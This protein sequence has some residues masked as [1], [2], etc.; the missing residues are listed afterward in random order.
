MKHL[1]YILLPALMFFIPASYVLSY[2]A[3]VPVKNRNGMYQASYKL[4]RGG[5]VDVNLPAD[6]ALDESVSGSVVY[7]GNLRQFELLI[8]DKPVLMHGGGNFTY[9]LPGN[10]ST[11]VVKVV[12]RYTNGIEIGKAF[13]PVNI[14]KLRKTLDLSDKENFKL[15][16]FGSA[17]MPLLING[18]F[19]GNYTNTSVTLSDK[20]LRILA[21]STTTCVFVTDNN[22]SGNAVLKISELGNDQQTQFTNLTVVKVEERE[23]PPPPE[24]VYREGE[25][26]QKRMLEKDFSR[27]PDP[28][29][30]SPEE[31]NLQDSGKVIN[32][33]PEEYT[34][35][36]PV[37]SFSRKPDN[38]PM[39]YS[40]VESE[41]NRQLQSDFYPNNPI[42]FPTE[43]ENS[44]VSENRYADLSDANEI[45]SEKM[46]RSTEEQF[47]VAKSKKTPETE[48][49]I[50]E[51]V[52]KNPETPPL[53]QKEKLP[54]NDSENGSATK[55]VETEDES[56]KHVADKVEV[57]KKSPEIKTENTASDK[58]AEKKSGADIK[59]QEI[60]DDRKKADKEKS[61]LH[62]E[63]GTNEY[64]TE[65]NKKT[66]E[67]KIENA[68]KEVANGKKTVDKTPA[69]NKPR[70]I[71]QI[72]EEKTPGEY[73]ILKVINP[74]P[75]QENNKIASII[76]TV[77]EKDKSEQP[78]EIDPQPVGKTD[79]TEQY[80]IQLASFK[81]QGEVENFVKIVKELGYRE[82]VKEVNVPGKG[83]WHRVR[84]C[85]FNSRNAAESFEKEID[86]KRLNVSSIYVTE[87]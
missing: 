8:E 6:M 34:A 50:S 11:G 23:P 66:A 59:G 60:M 13:F 39:D 4:E 53:P 37:R 36:N 27:I 58:V 3:L 12:L 85:D 2:S 35:V 54:V 26:A 72:E 62:K 7:Q 21:E 80:C 45:K 71:K 31:L 28:G 68:E 70:E 43:Q 65:E 69:V 82:D 63:S 38:E 33:K 30:I 77:P 32:T 67:T 22:Q 15:P 19:D 73:D 86:K 24:P 64:S 29:E 44:L 87:Y 10:V 20:R 52:I 79:N 47:L 57:Q 49:N 61:I 76:D 14:G 55:I 56:K 75:V 40:V 9:K 41:L 83:K 78:K 46:D 16:V 51:K 42:S 18:K 25:L 81:K 5:E 84:I 1:N 74:E 48:V 17:G